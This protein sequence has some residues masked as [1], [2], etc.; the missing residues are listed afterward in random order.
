MVTPA[1]IVHLTGAPAVGKRTIA[2]AVV[3]E[4]AARGRHAVLLDNHRTGNLILDVVGADGTSALPAGVWDRVGEVREVVFSAI[5]DLSPPDWSFVVTNV[6]IAGQ[7]LDEAAARRVVELA[8][9]R[10]SAYVPVALTCDVDV[11]VERVP[12]PDRAGLRKWIDP[13]GVRE[14]VE[15]REL[16]VPDGSL[17]LDT[18]TLPP[19]EAAQQIVDHLEALHS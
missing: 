16:I 11:L 13:A 9:R 4:M 8:E 18:T 19:A 2:L 1:P 14:L 6:L 10:G 17:L 3:D 5:E 12:N 15:T 7:P